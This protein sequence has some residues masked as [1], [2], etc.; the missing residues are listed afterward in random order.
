MPWTLPFDAFSTTQKRRRAQ[1]D[2]LLEWADGVLGEIN[3]L[4]D[5]FADAL[6]D[7]FGA[8][9][10]IYHNQKTHQYDGAFAKN[11]V[12]VTPIGVLLARVLV[13]CDAQYEKIGEV[14]KDA[15]GDLLRDVYA[16]AC[17]DVQWDLGKWQPVSELKEAQI[18]QM[19]DAKW[20]DGQ[21]FSDRL[22][23][24]KEA[25][26]RALR[27]TLTQ[28]V[29]LGWSVRQMASAFGRLLQNARYVIE[30]LIRTEAN[31]VQ[32]MALI[33][34]Y[35]ANGVKKYEYVAIMDDRTSE[36]CE[37]LN[38][39]QFPVSEAEVGV[40]VP[41]MHPNCRSS[42]IP[43]GRHTTKLDKDVERLDYNAWVGRF[44]GK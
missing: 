8:F 27:R 33:E 44:L 22:W 29:N 17:Y 30:R 5:V 36:V 10:A 16:R 40:N 7:K 3:P 41:P 39:R 4:L 20:F 1:A 37:E 13:V 18:A 2:W 34:A 9:A 15:F 31:R 11:K 19:A 24:D 12:G 6:Y 25:L 21:R 43:I 35:K 42:T 26:G 23:E 32:N 28:G 14:A 38:G